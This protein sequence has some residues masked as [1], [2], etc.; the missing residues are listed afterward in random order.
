MN[1]KIQYVL[2]DVSGT[3]LYKPTLYDTIFQVLNK[4]GY[5]VSLSEIKHKH[6]IIS[7]VI[8]FPDNT[9]KQ[10]YKIFNAELLYALGIIPNDTI[11]ENIFL[12]CSYLSWERF[13]DTDL[14][15][16]IRLPIG[17]LSNFNSS[18]KEKLNHFFGTIFD[19]ILVSEE[20]GMAKPSIEFYTKA[21]KKISIFPE[22]IL[23]IGDSLKLDIEP[24]LKVGMK[25]LLIDRENYYPNSDYAIKDLKQIL[26]YL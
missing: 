4:N 21:I 14:L 26:N 3:L 22:N 8:H 12:K 24:A 2:F 18:L 7:E 19:T 17:V 6:K 23:Y 15:S 10:F 9:D 16:Q 20:L 1:T 5:E 11:L 25:T 13:D